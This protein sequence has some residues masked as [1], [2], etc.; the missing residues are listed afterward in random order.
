MGMLSSGGAP[1]GMPAARLD[2]NNGRH[3]SFENLIRP[4]NWCRADLL[5]STRI[6]LK[7]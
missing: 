4:T 7:E 5:A 1:Q 3:G 6:G 2:F